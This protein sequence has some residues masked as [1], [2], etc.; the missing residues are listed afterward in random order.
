MSSMVSRWPVLVSLPVTAADVDDDGVLTTAAAERLF[1]RA[2][3]VY[4]AQCRTLAGRRIEV[5][6]VAVTPGGASVEPG[7]VTVSVSVVEVFA[8]RFS[9]NVRIRPAAG[10]GI[11]AD[12]WCDVFP[13][14]EVTTA[15]R[16]ELIAF[17]HEARH[18]H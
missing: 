11:A 8:D 9:M 16:D 3:E 5:L 1:E 13:G 18:Y 14:G 12:G 17:A 6:G 2:R 7:E 15:I 10:E 4:L